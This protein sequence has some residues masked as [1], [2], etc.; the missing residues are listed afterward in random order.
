[1][2]DSRSGDE[3]HFSQPWFMLHVTFRKSKQTSEYTVVF[4]C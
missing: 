3:T 1:M 2:V 4:S